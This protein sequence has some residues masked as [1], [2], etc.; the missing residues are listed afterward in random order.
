MKLTMLLLT[1]FLVPFLIGCTSLKPLEDKVDALQIQ[2]NRVD[3]AEQ[4]HGG[5]VELDAGMRE[6]QAA[7]ENKDFDKG[8][9]IQIQLQKLG[10]EVQAACQRYENIINPKK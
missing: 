2:L 8:T 5:F 6:L 4:C 1:L 3:A 10:F 7:I 9:E